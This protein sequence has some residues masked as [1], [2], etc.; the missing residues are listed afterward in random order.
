MSNVTHK[1][2]ELVAD[3]EKAFQYI[4]EG[5]ERYRNNQKA[6][7]TTDEQDRAILKDGQKPFAAVVTCAD[8][9]VAPEIYLDL[10]LGDIFVVRNAGNVVDAAALGSI[11]YAAEH[12]KVPLIMVIGHSKCGAVTGALHGGEF[13]DNLALV[14]EKISEAIHGSDNLDDAIKANIK[15]AVSVIQANKVVSEFAVKVIGAF[16]DIETG[17]VSYMV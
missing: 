11:E 8:S 14:I 12:L 1:P 5:N 13:S 9:R 17:T 4:K 3:W 6:P 7:R 2:D 16:Y 10:A 15:Y